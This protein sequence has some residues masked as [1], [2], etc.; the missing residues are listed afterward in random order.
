MVEEEEEEEEEED[1][2]EGSMT[3]TDGIS[4]AAVCAATAPI[5]SPAGPDA[6]PTPTAFRAEIP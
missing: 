6:A 4:L 2:E 1:A 5:A 3:F